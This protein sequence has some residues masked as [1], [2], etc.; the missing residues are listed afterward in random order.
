MKCEQKLTIGV[1][2][3]GHLCNGEMDEKSL[4][5]NMAFGMGAQ[6]LYQCKACK[7][8]IIRTE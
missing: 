3:S 2:D 4:I 7:N 5:D 8:I 6:V 1:L